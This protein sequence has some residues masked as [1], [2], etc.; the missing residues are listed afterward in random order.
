MACWSLTGSYASILNNSIYDNGQLGID[1]GGDGV[2]P[3]DVGDP[4]VGRELASE[5]PGL[6]AS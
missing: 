1:L 6:V 3:N 5:L 4:D 2:T